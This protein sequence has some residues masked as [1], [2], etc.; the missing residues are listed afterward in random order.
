MSTIPCWV[1]T[2]SYSRTLAHLTATAL[3]L[4]VRQ[5]SHNV[6]ECQPCLTNCFSI[7]CSRLP[8]T[9]SRLLRTISS[10]F[11]SFS[12]RVTSI[13]VPRTAPCQATVYCN[14]LIYLYLTPR[15]ITLLQD[16]HE[17]RLYIINTQ[18]YE[19]IY[20]PI[21]RLPYNYHQSQAQSPSTSV[22]Y[23]QLTLP[24]TPYV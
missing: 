21:L 5:L 23:T 2:T 12:S 1:G 15:R 22:S 14:F 3:A 17:N 24:T 9:K 6:E 18:I 4:R 16:T 10:L 11:A 7:A 13:Y 20:N 8:G 19:S